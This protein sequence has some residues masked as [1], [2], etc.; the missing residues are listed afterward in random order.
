[1]TNI[2]HLSLANRLHHTNGLDR[3]GVIEN[4]SIVPISNSNLCSA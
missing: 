4:K 3:A 2:S 1:M